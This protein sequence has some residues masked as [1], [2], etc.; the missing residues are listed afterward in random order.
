[1]WPSKFSL[2]LSSELPSESSSESS[3]SSMHMWLSALGE[4]ARES[5][6][7]ISALA[8]S[9]TRLHSQ[10]CISGKDCILS[11]GLWDQSCSKHQQD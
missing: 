3:S 2:M 9:A 1:M 11:R 8:V 5:T 6:R 10:F 7:H 4:P